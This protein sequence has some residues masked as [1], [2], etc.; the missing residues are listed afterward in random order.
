M[1]HSPAR[2]PKTRRADPEQLP[3]FELGESHRRMLQLLH[4][5]RYLTASLLALAYSQERGRGR[6]HVENELGK[7]Y[8]RGYVERFY[9][10]TRPAGYGSDAFVY[11]L[12]PKGGHEI[13]DEHGKYKSARL[14]LYN[15]A[16]PKANYP[17]HLAV[18]TLQLILELGAGPWKLDA[19][20]ADDAEQT[21]F[22]VT[23]DHRRH[24][25]YPDALAVLRFPNG[26]RSGYFFELDLVHRNEK[27]LDARFKAYTEHLTANRDDLRG[28]HGIRGAAT[29]FVV[30][31]E[32]EL[33]RTIERA[34]EAL[35]DWGRKDRPVFL[36]WNLESWYH[37]TKTGRGLNEPRQILAADNAVTIAGNPRRLV[38]T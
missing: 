17:H 9:Y 31:S 30:P 34:H 27:L 8:H 23:V 37:A 26:K 32:H 35:D 18:S 20:Y 16:K 21:K 2:L 14:A 6:S 11:S 10:S 15:R 38:N 12:A 33:V 7:L 1:R 28:A 4:R 22:T 29:V 3:P 5:Y 19:F 36:F 24:T 25:Y 13:L